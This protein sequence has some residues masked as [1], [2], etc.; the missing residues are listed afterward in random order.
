MINDSGKFKKI[1]VLINSGNAMELGWLDEYHVDACLWIGQPGQRGFE[2]VANILTG[3]ANPSGKLVDTY[4]ENS[5]SA[6]S[7]VNGGYHNQ[8]WTNLDQV[9]ASTTEDEAD[10][11]FYSV[12]AEGIYLGYKY[13][14]TRYEDCIL[15][16]GNA[17]DAAGASYNGQWNYADEIVYPFGYGLSYTQFEQSLDSVS[18]DKENIKVTVTVKNTGN[19]SGKSVVQ[20]YAQTPYGDYEKKNSVEKSSIQLLD[21]GKTDMLA[22]GESQ[23]LTVDCDKYLLTSYDYTKEKGYILSEGDYYIA[24]GNDAHD[25]LNNILAKKGESGLFDQ[26]KKPVSGNCSLHRTG[27]K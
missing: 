26:D 1:I 2:G 20:I 13:Y 4:A 16:Q 24:I 21:F 6:P 14:E 22:P 3:L 12:Q 10:V 17:T 27:R 11:S 8:Q 9:F 18:V 19:V 15:N 25:A 23:T 5:L 7:T